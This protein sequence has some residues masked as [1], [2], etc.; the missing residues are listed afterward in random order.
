MQQRMDE[1][2][3][4][5]KP[6]ETSEPSTLNATIVAQLRRELKIKIA[7]EKGL[8]SELKPSEARSIDQQQDY[9]RS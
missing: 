9:Q 1:H 8:Q 6:F 5:H 7:G 2:D 4:R 3:R